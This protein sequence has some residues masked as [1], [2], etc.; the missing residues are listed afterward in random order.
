M[1]AAEDHYATLGVTRDADVIVIRA[2]YRALA[3]RYHP[4]TAK[5]PKETAEAVFR[6]I[7]EA[8]EIL[9]DA[10]RRAA[11]D[12]YLDQ[13]AATKPDRRT[14]D[15]YFD[16]RAAAEPDRRASGPQEVRNGRQRKARR[17]RHRRGR[18]A[19]ALNKGKDFALAVFLVLVG[20]VVL[21]GL[22]V[23]VLI[24][25]QIGFDMID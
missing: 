8:Y 15:S 2:A 5:E 20:G 24:A 13:R 3:K 4:D 11:H 25:Y 21:L 18:L 22:I 6:K 23:V 9:S 10:R 17:H 1:M 12:F 16:R 7:N 14:Y 19:A